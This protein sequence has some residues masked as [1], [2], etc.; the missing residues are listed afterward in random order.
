MPS[1]Q[2]SFGP[3][4]HLPRPAFH[5][6][7]VGPSPLE[8]PRTVLR[9]A[10]NRFITC[11]ILSFLACLSGTRH[12]ITLYPCLR[13]AHLLHGQKNSRK[14][15]TLIIMNLRL[16]DKIPLFRQPTSRRPPLTLSVIV[17]PSSP[18]TYRQTI[19]RVANYIR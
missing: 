10:P 18:G 4:H 17:N 2:N 7:C 3:V 12:S 15:I 8:H 14:N 5:R 1:H 16:F 6:R 9:T 11:P 13:L 19:P